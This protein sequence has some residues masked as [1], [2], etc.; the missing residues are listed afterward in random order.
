MVQVA[1]SVMRGM[2][3]RGTA[4]LIVTSYD[5]EESIE[6]RNTTYKAA[7][8]KAVTLS[9]DAEVMSVDVDWLP[10]LHADTVLSHIPR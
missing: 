9:R 10:F 5:G 2:N 4:V 7:L 8:N 3:P 6:M 1:G